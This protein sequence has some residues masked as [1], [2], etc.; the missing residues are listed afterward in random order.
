MLW[1]GKDK[2]LKHKQREGN[3]FEGVGKELLQQNETK[4]T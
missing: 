2:I 4:V 3:Q 1:C